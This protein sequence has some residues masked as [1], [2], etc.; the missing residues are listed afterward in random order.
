MNKAVFTLVFLTSCFLFI[1]TSNATLI[2]IN[3]SSMTHFVNF[4]NLSDE[5]MIS[6]DQAAREYIAPDFVYQ[7]AWHTEAPTLVDND[8]DGRATDFSEYQYA[9][10]IL[11]DGAYAVERMLLQVH[12]HPFND[13]V[14]QGSNDTTTG[15]DGTWDNLLTNTSNISRYDYTWIG[16]DVDNDQAYSAYRLEIRSIPYWNIA[17][18][19]IFR[20]S[21]LADD[22]SYVDHSSVPEPTTMLLFGLGIL[23]IAGV[24]RKKTA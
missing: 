3:D 12:E 22:S 2:K 8:G 9:G 23:G 18:W 13:F 17:G 19:G 20:W 21:L 7:L 16:W 10:V 24:S 4:N 15:L 5:N 14:L 11:G 6:S 1:G